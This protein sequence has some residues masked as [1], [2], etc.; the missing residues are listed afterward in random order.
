MAEGTYLSYLRNVERGDVGENQ[1]LLPSALGRER[2]VNRQK[3]GGVISPIFYKM[4][5]D[6]ERHKRGGCY[7]KEKQ[8]GNKFRIGPSYANPVRQPLTPRLLRSRGYGDSR[9]FG[10]QGVRLPAA[11]LPVGRVGRDCGT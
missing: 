7:E 3:W 1:H 4:E 6:Q 10:G 5:Q 9:G 8:G 11:C 2:N